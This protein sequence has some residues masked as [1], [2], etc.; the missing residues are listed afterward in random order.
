MS[1]RPSG[2]TLVGLG[3]TLLTCAVLQLAFG[4]DLLVLALGLSSVVIGFYP[5][6]FVGRDLYTLLAA[7]FCFRY[8]GGALIAK[9]LYGQPLDLYLLAPTESY[10]LA[11]VLMIVVVAVFLL[12]RRLDKGLTIIPALASVEELRKVGAIAFAV[13]ISAGLVAG[14]NLVRDSSVAATGAVHVI[15]GAL[16]NLVFLGYSAE[17]LHTITVSNRRKVISGRLVLM[18]LL[19]TGLA[20]FLNVRALVV[21]GGVC[22]FVCAFLLRAIRLKHLLGGGLLFL[23][24]TAY[25]SPIALELR[26]LKEGKSASQYASDVADVVSKTLTD[27]AYVASIR[28]R[29]NYRQRYDSG[30]PQYDYFSDNSNIANRLSFVALLDTVYYQTLTAGQIGWRGFEE[31]YARVVPSFLAA[32]EERLFGYGDW[33]SWELGLIETGRVAYFSFPLPMEG[34]ALFGL[35]GLVLFPVLFMTPVLLIAGRIASFRFA[36]APSLFLVSALHWELVEGASDTYISL[37]LRVLPILVGPALALF[38][39]WSQQRPFEQPARLAGSGRR[40]G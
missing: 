40:S 7:L 5:V 38:W 39:A 12:A 17:L 35:T 19:A 6:L 34:L 29:D 16:M 2:W 4:A 11:N 36:T 25:L 32:K 1:I 14:A 8:T 31:V 23:I 22:I 27:S 24:F 28:A 37:V 3:A 30:T 10:A 9:T 21:N 20:L 15:S 13:G 18:L 26:T 33:L